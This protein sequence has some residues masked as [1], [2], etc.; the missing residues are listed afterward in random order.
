MASLPYPRHP[1]R[2]CSGLRCTNQAIVHQHCNPPTESTE[3]TETSGREEPPTDF[4]DAHRFFL[5]RQKLL[6]IL[7]VLW[8]NSLVGSP[9]LCV[10]VQSVEEYLAQPETSVGSVGECADAKKALISLSLRS[11]VVYLQCKQSIGL[12][13]NTSIRSPTGASSDCSDRSSANHC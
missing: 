9:N 10:S 1:L 2:G 3:F 7:W 4:T 5:L 8:E 11:F 13:A 6:W 12:W